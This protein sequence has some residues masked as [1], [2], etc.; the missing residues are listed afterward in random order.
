MPSQWVSSFEHDLYNCCSSSQNENCT[1]QTQILYNVLA[2]EQLV[3]FWNKTIYCN[4][5]QS[6]SNAC[7][8]DTTESKN[9]NEG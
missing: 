4:A 2:M 7:L 8:D 3:L 9:Y 6:K 1:L 5:R